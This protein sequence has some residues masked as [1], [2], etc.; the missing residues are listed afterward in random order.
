M[1]GL[2]QI[3][4]LRERWDFPATLAS[5]SLSSVWAPAHPFR[6]LAKHD[7]AVQIPHGGMQMPAGSRKKNAF[8]RFFFCASD[9][10]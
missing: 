5:P 8:R 10:I 7:S 3:F 6:K 2:Y 9:G 1:S 4:S